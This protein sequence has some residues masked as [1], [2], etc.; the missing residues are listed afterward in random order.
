MITPDALLVFLGAASLPA[1]YLFILSRW[2]EPAYRRAYPE[3]T[4]KKARRVAQRELV[5]PTALP[6]YARANTD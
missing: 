4:E 2:I 6:H 5:P 1:I 3:T